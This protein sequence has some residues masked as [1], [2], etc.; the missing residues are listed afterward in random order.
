MVKKAAAPAAKKAAAK[1]AAPK[2]E[3]NGEAPEPRPVEVTDEDLLSTAVS[4]DE[5]TDYLSVV[6]YGEHGTGKTTNACSMANVVDAPV[7][8][9]NAEAGLKRRAL[10]QRGIDTAQLHV[11]PN[12]ERGQS[13][14]F[15]FLEALFWQAKDALERTPGSIGGFVWDSVTEIHQ[16]LLNNIVAED[17]ARA[18]R[19]GRDR[20]RFFKSQDN[21]GVMAA[22]LT[23]LLRRFRDLPCHFAATALQRRDIDDDGK[24][25]YRPAVTPA[26]QTPIGGI[27][28]LIGHT[29]VEE[30]GGHEQYI[31][32]FKPIGKYSGKDRYSVLPTHLVDPTFARIHGYVTGAIDPEEDPVMIDAA[33]ARAETGGRK[34]RRAEQIDADVSDTAG[35]DDE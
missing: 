13:L 11:L 16:I 7:Y 34:R 21:Y 3:R 29:Y 23:E 33:R 1:K 31:G 4:L 15:E 6:W 19:L 8:V 24:V 22:Q 5:A 28:D 25:V 10:E 12:L 26:L 17:V 20:D 2:A 18:E 14:T 32:T 9:I 35:A 30:V 27:P